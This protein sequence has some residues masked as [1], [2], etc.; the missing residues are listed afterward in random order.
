MHTICQSYSRLTL[1][2]TYSAVISQSLSAKGLSR[3]AI[4]QRSAFG[5]LAPVESILNKSL[6]ANA[7]CLPGDLSPSCIGVYKVPIDDNILPF[8]GTETALKKNAPDLS[9]VPPIVAPKSVSDALETLRKQRL[10]A[11]EIVQIVTAGRLEE[12]GIK[13]LELLPKV[14]IAGR[15][16]VNARLDIQ[17]A[18]DAIQE[19]QQ[20]QLQNS[21]DQVYVS[22][23]S[24]DVLIGQGLRGEMGASVVAQ[25]TILA[26]LKDATRALDDLIAATRH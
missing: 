3:R 20:Q 10:L 26:E 15:L 16:I 18:S 21:F 14:T 22:W 13:V 17:G 25:L 2:F 12:A 24:V 9:Y 5:V 19:L 8:I 7:A 23:N 11:D 4:L 1:L 6:T